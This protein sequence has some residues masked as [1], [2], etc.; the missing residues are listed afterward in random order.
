MTGGCKKRIII[1]AA[2]IATTSLCHYATP[3]HFKVL[4][5]VLTRLYYL[6]IVLGGFWFGLRGGLVTS[7]AISSIYLPHTFIA[8]LEESWILWNRLLEIVLFNTFGAIIGLLTE[9]ERRQI[10]RNQ[11]LQ[12]LAALGESAAFVAHELKNVI[13]PIRGFIMRMRNKMPEDQQPTMCLDIVDRESARLEDMVKELMRFAR[14]TPLSLESVDITTLLGEAVE[15]IRGEY[16]S[17]NVELVA[18]TDGNLPLVS[19]DREG[20]RQILTNLLQN[21]LEASSANGEV[22]LRARRHRDGVQISVA[23]QG[24]G[25]RQEDARHIYMPFFT[26]KPGGNGLGLAMVRR[27]ISEHGGTIDVTSVPD[28]GTTFTL[29]LPPNPPTSTPE[30]T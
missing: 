21:A 20:I 30:M 1:V 18:E 6:P 13:I 27:I 3:V 25:I 14:K 9:R 7:A 28:K 10:M 22:R 24:C 26:T 19:V 12:S 5:D 29:Q 23:D 4:H 17:S 15:A 16:A 2:T 11:R 8:W